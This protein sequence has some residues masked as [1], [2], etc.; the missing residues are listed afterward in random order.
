VEVEE[1]GEGR[2]F[3]E[4]LVDNVPHGTWL[5]VQDSDA[6]LG[7]N[8]AQSS[9]ERAMRKA[10]LLEVKGHPIKSAALRSRNG[11]RVTGN[12]GKLLA[13]KVLGRE[14]HA[15]ELVLLSIDE[16]TAEKESVVH[17]LQNKTHPV[18]KLVLQ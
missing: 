10:V 7:A 1:K 2:L 11:Q 5:A 14:R 9:E 15:I 6:F 4:L 18:T 8:T 13:H 12:N 16:G 17:V 3:Q